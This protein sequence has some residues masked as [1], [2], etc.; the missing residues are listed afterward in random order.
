[1]AVKNFTKFYPPNGEC[2]EDFY[3]R[4]ADFIEEIIEKDED[5]L[6][7]SHNGTMRVI[8]MMLIEMGDNISKLYFSQG[9]YTQIGVKEDYKY[10]VCFNK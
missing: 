7:V 10:L 1:M 6:I 4:V 2:F 5:V 9:D 3:S 8:L